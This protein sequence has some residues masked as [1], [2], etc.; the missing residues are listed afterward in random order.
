MAILVVALCTLQRS[1]TINTIV[2]GADISDDNNKTSKLEYKHDITTLQAILK[3]LAPIS[4]TTKNSPHS[5]TVLT[6]A[7]TYP[8][9]KSTQNILKHVNNKTHDNSEDATKKQAANN[10]ISH[11]L[12]ASQKFTNKSMVMQTTS[13]TP[14]THH[15]TINHYR[16]QGIT[17]GKQSATEHL[18]NSNTKD[19]EI[20]QKQL[21]LTYCLIFYIEKE[22]M[23]Y[24]KLDL[25]GV[26]VILKT[27]TNTKSISTLANTTVT[28]T[29]VYITKII[30][31][32]TGWKTEDITKNQQITQ[33]KN[34][35]EKT[36][37]LVQQMKD[38]LSLTDVN[39][40]RI[41]QNG[42]KLSDQFLSQQLLKNYE[43]ETTLLNLKHQL[44]IER[45]TVAPNNNMS[46]VLDSLIYYPLLQKYMYHY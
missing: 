18:T 8:S 26:Y 37:K 9:E 36:M 45:P 5:N 43:S 11:A 42:Y 15:T 25:W 20:M 39:T 28:A 2:I 44:Y 6:T 24:A 23:E 3:V 31:T 29:E 21:N 12:F 4:G 16:D 33:I 38:F 14:E 1:T 27:A 40:M 17:E 35:L 19:F 34:E 46:D 13:K 10:N 41:Y 22:K 7:P 32:L 30:E